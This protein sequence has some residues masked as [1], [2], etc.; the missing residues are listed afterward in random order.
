MKIL[1]L[2]WRDTGHPQGGGSERYLEQVAEY[3]AT[4]GHTVELWTAHYPGAKHTERTSFGLVRRL[5]G[6][7]T[8]Y[9]RLALKMLAHRRG[10]DIVVDTQ[11]GIP[12][13]AKLWV[14]APVVVL[15]HHCHKEQWPVAG[16]VLSRLGWWLESKAAP[17]LYRGNTYVTVSES[18]KRELVGLGIDPERI[19]VVTNGADPVPADAARA[20]TGVGV[21]PA[22]GSG[23]G[24]GKDTECGSGKVPGKGSGKSPG[25]D[26][27]GD[28][29]RLVTLSR[30]VP[31]KQI[32]HA[33]DVLAA[34]RVQMPVVLDVIGDGWWREQLVEYAARLGVADAVVFHGH[35]DE[36]TKHELLAGAS[37]HLMPSVKEGWGLAVI[38]AAQHAV[39]TVGYLHSAGLNDSVVDGVTGVLV[40]DKASLIAATWQLL[41]DDQARTQ[42]GEAAQRRAREFSWEST[43]EQFLAILER[44]RR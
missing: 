31:H 4:Q 22:N 14:A 33:M 6:K 17:A 26:L 7:Y 35:V 1:L 3:L 37:V 16:P 30:L 41:T 39:P 42:M 34:A 10:F 43:G 23:S 40:P 2:C 24:L 32:E 8:V 12:F 18:S 36:P 29:V 5:G 21:N 38:E 28:T 15:T 44:A 13:F 25:K 11:N 9:P 19:E 20:A 27:G